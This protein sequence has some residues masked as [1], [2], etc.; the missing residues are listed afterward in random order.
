MSGILAIKQQKEQLTKIAIVESNG[1]HKWPVCLS[2]PLEMN[3][4][5]RDGLKWQRDR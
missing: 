2:G 3:Q 5:C 1:H 4:H